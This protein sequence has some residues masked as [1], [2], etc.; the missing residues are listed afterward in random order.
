VQLLRKRLFWE[1]PRAIL[2]IVTI[3]AAVVGTPINDERERR[4]FEMLAYHTVE[5]IGMGA[6]VALLLVLAS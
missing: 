4:L 5:S 2:L 6:V 1:T 3:T